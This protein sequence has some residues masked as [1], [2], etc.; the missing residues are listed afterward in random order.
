[1][2]LRIFTLI[3][4]IMAMY[5]AA[6]AAAPV[7]SVTCQSGT[8]YIS[9]EIALGELDAP[10]AVTVTVRDSNGNL[11]YADVIMAGTDGVAKFMYNNLG[12]SGNYVCYFDVPS[13]NITRPV[14]IN[15]FI[16]ND[17]WINF[18]NDISDY[19]KEKNWESVRDRFLGESDRL[20]SDMTIY[21]SLADKDAVFKVF[22]N[23]YTKLEETKD[24]LDEFDKAA[25]LC[26]FNENKS[27]ENLIA[28]YKEEATS[29]YFGI[30]EV[31]PDST[32]EG[33]SI[34]DDLSADLQ[35][36][37][38]GSIAGKTYESSKLL[39]EEFVKQTLLITVNKAENYGVV[40]KVYTA[41]QN[42]ELLEL[43]QNGSRT[44]DEVCKEIIGKTY[45]S[46]PEAQND[47]NNIAQTPKPTVPSGRPTGGG[48]GSVN[49]GL[50]NKVSANNVAAVP[51]IPQQSDTGI[52]SG[53]MY[54]EDMEDAKWALN[55]VNN[56]YE[57]K[58]ISGTG[59]K[60][61][62]PHRNVSRCEMAKLIVNT[63]GMGIIDSGADFTDI[64]KSQWYYPFVATAYANGVFT[65]YEDGSF[66]THGSI[67]RQ[68]AAL[69]IYRLVKPIIGEGSGADFVFADDAEVSE[70]AKTAV[71]FLKN[72][73]I[74]NGRS[75]DEF[76]PNETLT[77][78]EAAVLCD[79]VYKYFEKEDEA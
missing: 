54:F 25:R 41:Y 60:T 49:A 39:C 59:E 67:T 24:I 75:D 51:M 45:T 2:K 18:V 44:M 64:D 40:K 79:K 12:N 56:L 9:G 28:L 26:S 77:R 32:G 16:G 43:I 14:P 27:T 33:I 29:N 47:Y 69:V 13:L 52:L 46:L 53:K 20:S 61:F 5:T 71:Y 22:V 1:M 74:M 3:L 76:R 63:A 55:A 58:I 78:V 7:T 50:N 42:A 21:N 57:K 11:N 30:L 72:A 35:N 62:S 17:Y 70:W 48:G 37:I 31:L 10:V 15:G 6:Y 23:N 4:C 38:F 19:C 66:N 34:I 8:T 65:G 36:I 73:N 68:E